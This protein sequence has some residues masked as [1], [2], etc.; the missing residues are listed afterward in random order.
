MFL[1]KTFKG[2]RK[3][4]KTRNCVQMQSIS[5]FVDIAKLADFL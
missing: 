1:K 3:V 2:S 5:V 4:K